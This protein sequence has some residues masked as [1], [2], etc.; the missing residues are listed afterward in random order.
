VLVTAVI[1]AIVGSLER[2]GAGRPTL[3]VPATY[4]P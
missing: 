2:S 4:M 1:V 3:P